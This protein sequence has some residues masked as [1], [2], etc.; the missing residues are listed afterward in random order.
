MPPYISGNK[1]ES[2]WADIRIDKIWES[3][4]VKLLGVNITET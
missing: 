4:N 2:I 1:H 3:N